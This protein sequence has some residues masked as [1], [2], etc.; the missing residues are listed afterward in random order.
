MAY[1]PDHLGSIRAVINQDGEIVE[2]RDYGPFGRMI[3]HSGGLE[4]EYGFTGQV[5]DPGTGLYDY[6]ARMYDPRWGRFISPDERVQPID[7]QGRSPYSYVLNRPTSLIDP[8]GEMAWIPAMLVVGATSAIAASAIGLLAPDQ[9]GFQALQSAL[10]GIA[11]LAAT[12]GLAPA[13][14]VTPTIGAI[15]ELGS[16][17]TAGLGI[18]GVLIHLHAATFP[19]LRQLSLTVEG[20]ALRSGPN[21]N[22]SLVPGLP[23]SIAIEMLQSHPAFQRGAVA[24]IDVSGTSVVYHYGDG[25]TKAVPLSE[26]LSGNDAVCPLPTADSTDRG[27]PPELPEYTPQAATF[28]RSDA[29]RFGYGNVA[30]QIMLAGWLA[31]LF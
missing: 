27:M 5:R 14:A 25:R 26:V 20:S 4:P 19:E 17:A 21:F 11:G 3:S 28:I 8:T 29:A 6:G 13:V 31:G 10:I 12:F 7:P 22:R 1:V 30:H 18:A 2:T 15:V 16:A 24:R 23:D 9:P